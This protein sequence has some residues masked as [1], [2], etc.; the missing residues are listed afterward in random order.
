MAFVVHIKV[1]EA[2]N[3]L[4]A[5]LLGKRDPFVKVY[6]KSNKKNVKKTKSVKNTLDPT[7]NDEF[8]FNVT[9]KQEK[10]KV[11]FHLYDE[12]TKS[13][14]ELAE[15]AEIPLSNYKIGDPPAASTLKLTL[16]KKDAGTLKVEINLLSQSSQNSPAV[17][18]KEP[19]PI[20]LKV[21]LVKGTN[22]HKMDK[23]GKS[24]PYCIFQL[25]GYPEDQ[26]SRWKS[27]VIDN[28]LDPVWN[29]EYTF[30]CKDWNTD[31]LVFQ[32]WDKDVIKDDQMVDTIEFPL[33][34]FPL[35]QHVT[36]SE[37]VKHKNKP[38]GHLDLEFDAIDLLNQPK[39]QQRDLVLEEGACDFTLGSYSSEYATSFS[40]ITCSHQLSDLH[41][42]EKVEHAS[43]AKVVEKKSPPKP[44]RLSESISGILIGANN[45]IKVGTEATNTYALIHVLTKALYQ[46]KGKTP[47]K[48]EVISDSTSPGYNLGFD[49]KKV[50][51]GDSLQI[52]IFQTNQPKGDLKIG[53]CVIPL[54]NIDENQTVEKEFDLEKPFRFPYELG[55]FDSFGKIK[56]SLTHNVQYK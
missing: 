50:S 45:L 53:E 6:L 1:C 48:S 15:K 14:D 39:I 56:L 38:G 20:Q 49:Y 52:E 46:K 2:H 17:P 36:W 29:E 9:E 43:H 33:N 37:D 11:V 54:K 5:G 35:N 13:H 23:I 41:S 26:L 3:L 44:V 24:D 28:T 42:S 12:G 16:K 55:N 4:K 18:Q 51:K 27:R 19:K 25:K 31:V 22:L 8:E 7:W 40:S 47:Q 34:Q 10:E 32:M 30:M 21:K